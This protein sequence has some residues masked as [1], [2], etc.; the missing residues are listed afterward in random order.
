MK[1][2]KDIGL[3]EQCNKRKLKLQGDIVVTVLLQAYEN[4]T[5]DKK[6]KSSHSK[7]LW[8]REW[9]GVSVGIAHW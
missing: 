8:E 7:Y 4:N 2:W 5:K 3:P 1:D 6:I 9:V